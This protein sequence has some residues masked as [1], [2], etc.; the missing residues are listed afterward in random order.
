MFRATPTRLVNKSLCQSIMSLIM[1]KEMNKLPQKMKKRI[2]LAGIFYPL[3]QNEK[4]K[5]GRIMS[6]GFDAVV[7]KLKLLA[8]DKGYEQ[9]E[10]TGT[11]I[12]WGNENNSGI[13]C[14]F[15]CVE[16][17][18]DLAQVESIFKQI[19]KYE[20]VFY[21]CHSPSEKRWRGNI[22]YIQIIRDFVIWNIANRVQA[23]KIRKSNNQD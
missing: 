10:V 14:M 3:D 6:K 23:P 4:R 9:T 20:P 22:R 7:E 12:L 13:E 15:Y 16:D 11:T 1:E 19:R 5:W 8:E 18:M 21:L 17:A 2:D